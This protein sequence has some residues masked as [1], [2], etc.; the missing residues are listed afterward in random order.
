MTYGRDIFERASCPD[1]ED[2]KSLALVLSVMEH[3]PTGAMLLADVAKQEPKIFLKA[4][5]EEIL[6]GGLEPDGETIGI[7]TAMMSKFRGVEDIWLLATLGHE[8]QHVWQLRRKDVVGT[9]FHLNVLEENVHDRLFYC[10]MT[11]ADAVSLGIQL[12]GEA[13]R[14]GLL[15]DRNPCLE[16]TL[17]RPC[18]EAFFACME[19]D[20]DSLDD[21]RAR[22]AAAEAWMEIPKV[23]AYYE[24]GSLKQLRKGI[25]H[26][27]KLSAELRPMLAQ[28]DEEDQKAFFPKSVWTDPSRRQALREALP[29]P[30]GK[31]YLDESIFSD[32]AWNEVEPSNRRRGHFVANRQAFLKQSLFTGFPAPAPVL[33][34]RFP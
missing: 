18:F 9:P 16:N 5:M 32:P 3:T 34:V 13:H 29:M 23:K 31:P 24:D 33:K 7:N 28:L 20:P 26:V 19:K 2:R 21:G 25:S 11:E 12:C 10:R 14:L 15:G 4:D 1:E 8:L 22:R 30:D 17:Y 6:G 27:E